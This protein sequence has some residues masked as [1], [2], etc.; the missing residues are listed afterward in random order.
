MLDTRKRLE[1]SIAQIESASQ[2]RTPLDGRFVPEGLVLV[3]RTN[4]GGVRFAA[5]EL[6]D[7]STGKKL[8]P[9]ILKYA[10]GDGWSIKPLVMKDAQ[11]PFAPRFL[12]GFGHGRDDALGRTWFADTSWLGPE[13]DMHAGDFPDV[14]DQAPLIDAEGRL[15]F[16]GTHVVEQ[17]IYTRG[18]YIMNPSVPAT[19]SQLK[20]F[21]KRINGTDEWTA[22]TQAADRAAATQKTKSQ[23]SK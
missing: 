23:S 13:G 22:A 5:S 21:R 16:S 3:A 4:E 15:F 6:T 14:F 20:E 7:L 10:P 9:T 8:G 18:R 2:A 12:M 17:Y 11:R 19:A 1:S